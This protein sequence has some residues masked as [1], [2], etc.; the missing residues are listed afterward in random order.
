MIRQRLLFAVQVGDVVTAR[1]WLN[2]LTKYGEQPFPFYYAYAKGRYFFAEK[3][4]KEAQLQFDTALKQLQDV[5]YALVRNRSADLAGDLPGRPGENIG[6]CK[7]LEGCDQRL[8]NG[9]SAP[10]L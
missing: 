1:Q 4:F 9:E 5:D 10:S 3:K 6:R 7:N 8:A 2:T